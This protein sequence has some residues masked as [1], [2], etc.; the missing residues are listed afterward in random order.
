MEY[1]ARVLVIEDHELVHRYLCEAV[2]TAG[3]RARCVRTKAEAEVELASGGIDLVVSDIRLPD[4]SGNDIAL[5]AAGMGIKT[6]LMTGHPDT[7]AT[8]ASKQIAHLRKPFRLGALIKLIEDH[9]GAPGPG[10]A[11]ARGRDGLKDDEAKPSS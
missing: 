4:G 11:G 10:E 1:M 7:I 6:I 8:L 5:R 3:H 2:R 9:L